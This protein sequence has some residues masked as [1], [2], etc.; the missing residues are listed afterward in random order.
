ME[1]RRYQNK[2]AADTAMLRARADSS[3][4]SESI[5]EH[6]CLRLKEE[7]RTEVLQEGAEREH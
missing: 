2:E 4:R 5:L 6:E 1:K 3:T 7:C